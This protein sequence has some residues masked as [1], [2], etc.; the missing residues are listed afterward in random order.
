MVEGIWYKV[1]INWLTNNPNLLPFNFRR[2][3][4]YG[5]SL[6]TAISCL[7]KARRHFGE[8]RYFGDAVLS[9][10]HWQG[11]WSNV[12]YEQSISEY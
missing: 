2:Y 3:C 9:V 5:N 4:Y 7:R 6:K 1:S 11:D 8:D 10:V 12:V